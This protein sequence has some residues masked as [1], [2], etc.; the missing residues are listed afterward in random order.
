MSK[1]SD[2]LD[3]NERLDVARFSTNGKILRSGSSLVQSCPLEDCE[4]NYAKHVARYKFAAGICSAI[5]FLNRLS[6]IY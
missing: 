1:N 2:P 4:A 3:W 5:W 6:A